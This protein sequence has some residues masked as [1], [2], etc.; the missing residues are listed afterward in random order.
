MFG[1]E[2]ATAIM[3]ELGQLILMDIIKGCLA[4][5][6][7]CKQKHKALRY[8]MVLKEKRCSC[9]KWQGCADVCKPRIYKTKE[10]RCRLQSALKPYFFKLSH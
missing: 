4:H 7:S 2:G 5:Q 6:M 1:Q 3:K 9:I 8:L 10:E